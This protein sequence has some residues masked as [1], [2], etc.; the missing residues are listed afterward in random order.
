MGEVKRNLNEGNILG[1]IL[2]LTLCL[3]LFLSNNK[4]KQTFEQNCIQMF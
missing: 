2:A 1:L 4:V 3:S